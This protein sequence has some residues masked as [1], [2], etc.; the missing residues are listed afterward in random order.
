M[1]KLFKLALLTAVT[2]AAQNTLD[3]QG[4]TTNQMMN[5]RWWLSVEPNTRTDFVFGAMDGLWL[6]SGMVGG[7]HGRQLMYM[8]TVDGFWYSDYVAEITHIYQSHPENRILPV[9]VVIALASDHFRGVPQQEIDAKS[10][11]WR[12]IYT[13]LRT[14]VTP[15]SP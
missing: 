9:V 15:H 6:A 12:R 11:R 1:K 4:L 10:V 3:Q 2:M 5:G 7:T 13:S 8:C 14:T